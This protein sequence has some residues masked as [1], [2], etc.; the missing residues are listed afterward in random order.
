MSRKPGI[1]IQNTDK[2]EENYVYA[3]WFNFLFWMHLVFV[4]MLCKTR[5]I[6]Y[7]RIKPYTVK[8]N[9]ISSQMI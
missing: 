5:L 8:V 6:R 1:Y 7:I 3:K 9:G 4:W 2:S